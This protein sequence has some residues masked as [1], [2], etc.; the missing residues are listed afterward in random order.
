MPNVDSIT[1]FRKNVF[2]NDTLCF[3]Q[4]TLYLINLLYFLQTIIIK[5]I[6]LVS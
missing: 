6:Y 4:V 2:L 5:H 3:P 1:G